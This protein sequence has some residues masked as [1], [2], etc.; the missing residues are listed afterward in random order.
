M[1]TRSVE[2]TEEQGAFLDGLVVEGRYPGVGEAMAMA[3]R[4]LREDEARMDLLIERLNKAYDES[5][6]LP[7]ATETGEEQLNRI[8]R[9]AREE[10]EAKEAVRARRAARKAS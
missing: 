2:L 6:D 10:W 4:L 3:L 8:F 7:P 5:L 9:E 1:A